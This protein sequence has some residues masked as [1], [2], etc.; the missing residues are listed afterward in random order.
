M[1]PFSTRIIWT[2]D[3]ADDPLSGDADGRDHAREAGGG[4]GDGLG[5]EGHGADSDFEK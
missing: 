5:V 1:G 2:A 3:R 4:D